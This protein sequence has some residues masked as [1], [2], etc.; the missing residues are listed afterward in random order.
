[1]LA[2]KASAELNQVL[3]L[4]PAQV[5]EDAVV[6]A[7]PQAA[8]GVLRIHVDGLHAGADTLPE[9]A[10][11][12]IESIWLRKPLRGRHFAQT[13]GAPLPPVPQIVEMRAAGE[14]RRELPGQSGVPKSTAQRPLAPRYLIAGLT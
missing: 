14:V 1:M 9:N 13:E 12:G 3:T 2:A 5:L 11:R 4:H 6:F 10:E 8:A 7:V